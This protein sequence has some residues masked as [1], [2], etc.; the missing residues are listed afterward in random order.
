MADK[1]CQILLNDPE[2]AVSRPEHA[3]AHDDDLM[4]GSTTF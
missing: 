3:D 2:M 4:I 1:V